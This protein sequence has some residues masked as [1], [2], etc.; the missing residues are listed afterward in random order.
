[1]NVLV[2]TD[3][4]IDHLRGR[5]AARRRLRQVLDGGRLYASV[6]TRAELL[7]GMRDDEEERT[8]AML[9]AVRW[10]GVDQPI[11][12]LA[13]SLARGHRSRHP[14]VGLPD[15]L[16]AATASL[17]ELELWTRNVRHFPMLPGLRPVY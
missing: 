2:D 15:Y 12:D 9:R 16:I 17:L 1:V 7:A 4:L 3:V 14:G 6:V 8:L 10:L 5:H 11:A 13:G